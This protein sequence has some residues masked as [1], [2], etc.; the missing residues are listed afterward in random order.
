MPP[1]LEN[2]V[3]EWLAI[4]DEDLESAKGLMG[5]QHWRQACFLTQQAVEKYLKA[6]LTSRQISYERTH[7]IESLAT[8]LSDAEQLGILKPAVFDLSEYAIDPRYPGF[9]ASQFGIE[10]V[11]RALEAAEQVSLSIHKALNL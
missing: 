11:N 7:N 2:V 9:D 8:L 1:D 10:D 4:A 6:L 3:R 5:L